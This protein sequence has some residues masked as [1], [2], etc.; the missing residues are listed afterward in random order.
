MLAIVNSVQK[1][2]RDILGN[3][4]TISINQALDSIRPVDK[5][6]SDHFD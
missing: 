1:V 5:D 3:V 2:I 4:V 6:R